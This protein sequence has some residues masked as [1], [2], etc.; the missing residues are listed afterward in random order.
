M[1]RNSPGVELLYAAK[2]IRLEARCVSDY[3]FYFS[4]PPIPQCRKIRT[5]NGARPNRRAVMNWV[6]LKLQEERCE[7]LVSDAVKVLWI[8][9]GDFAS[10]IRLSIT[11]SWTASVEPLKNN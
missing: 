5:K 11:V 1:W 8:L 10:L 3:V 6:W 7:Q 9:L 4:A 2:L